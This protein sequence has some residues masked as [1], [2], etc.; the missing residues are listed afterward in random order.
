MHV[1]SASKENILINAN[2]RFANTGENT[3]KNSFIK[4]NKSINM[5]RISKNSRFDLQPRD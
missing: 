2:L 3:T 4:Y 5:P 1:K